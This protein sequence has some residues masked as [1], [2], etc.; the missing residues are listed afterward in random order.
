MNILIAQA[1]LLCL[2]AITYNQFK[3]GKAIRTCYFQDP[4]LNYEGEKH[5][6]IKYCADS[7]EYRPKMTQLAHFMRTYSTNQ[8]TLASDFGSFVDVLYLRDKDLVLI[9]PV[10]VERSREVNLCVYANGNQTHRSMV[11]TVQYVGEDFTQKKITFSRKDSC[12]V[13]AILDNV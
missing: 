7:L 2:I 1:V 4:V 9:N 6:P 5:V 13:E 3:T 10:I 12:L 11:S 8:A